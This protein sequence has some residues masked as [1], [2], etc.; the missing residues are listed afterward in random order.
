MTAEKNERSLLVPLLA[1]AGV[2]IVVAGAV[3]FFAYRPT[4]ADVHG[5]VTLEDVAVAGAVI[6]FVGEDAKNQAP[7]IAV[8]DETGNYHLVGN[9]G[10][11]IPVGNYKVAVIKETLANGKVPDGEK[12]EKA[13]A[14]GSLANRLPKIYEDYKTTPLKFEIRS[15]G[16]TVNLRLKKQ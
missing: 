6:T 9:T 8:S 16:N 11:L 13:R 5:Q 14:D 7:I 3:W 2:L 15:G 10:T 12:L 4:S 1:I